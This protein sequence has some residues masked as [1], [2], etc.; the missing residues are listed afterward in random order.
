M[1]LIRDKQNSCLF[2]LKF[3]IEILKSEAYE[4]N[5]SM[6]ITLYF[7]FRKIIYN[8]YTKVQN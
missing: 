2:F 5:A 1:Y 6:I 7:V 3:L 8:Q 4:K